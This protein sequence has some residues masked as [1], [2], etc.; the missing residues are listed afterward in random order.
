MRHHASEVLGAAKHLGESYWRMRLEELGMACRMS[1]PA[2]QADGIR[3]A[4]DLLMLTPVSYLTQLKPRLAEAKLEAMMGAGAHESAALALL[5][6]G[7]GYML[8]RGPNGD[9]LASVILPESDEE[10]TAGGATAALALVAA[11]MA[12]LAELYPVSAQSSAC[13]N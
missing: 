1:E 7:A 11:L 8:S 5:P 3:E 2:G 12:E 4:F 9:H 6:A 13:I 10:M